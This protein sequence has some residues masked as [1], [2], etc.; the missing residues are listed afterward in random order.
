VAEGRE[1]TFGLFVLSSTSGDQNQ[2]AKTTLPTK[3]ST[4]LIDLK[5]N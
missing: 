5:I 3:N 4:K 2:A 1:G